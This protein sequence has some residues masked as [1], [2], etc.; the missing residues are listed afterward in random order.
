VTKHCQFLGTP[1]SRCLKPLFLAEH[2]HSFIYAKFAR[3]LNMRE[4]GIGNQT[5]Y[6]KYRKFKALPN[7]HRS[8]SMPRT[9]DPYTFLAW[10]AYTKK[11]GSKRKQAMKPGWMKKG[12]IVSY[13]FLL[14]CECVILTSFVIEAASILI[15]VMGN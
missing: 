5:S 15:H 4:K 11:S 10:T 7:H 2:K 3:L 9:E 1:E 12:S 6:P 13:R 8:I 14:F